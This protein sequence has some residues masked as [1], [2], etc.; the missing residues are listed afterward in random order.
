M[1][2]RRRKKNPAVSIPTTEPSLAA[3]GPATNSKA[4]S[5]ACSGCRVH[6]IACK[7][8][9]GETICIKCTE[10]GHS[11]ECVIQP[12]RTRQR[13]NSAL[14]HELPSK[15]TA[16]K[17]RAPTP[18]FTTTT[19]NRQQTPQLSDIAPHAKRQC[20]SSLHKPTDV[21]ALGLLASGFNSVPELDEFDDLHGLER[22]SDQTAEFGDPV[23]FMSAVMSGGPID[24]DSELEVDGDETQCHEYFDLE[25]ITTGSEDDKSSLGDSDTDDG[26][27]TLIEQRCPYLQ[28]VAKYAHTKRLP[29]AKPASKTKASMEPS[30]DPATCV[31]KIRGAVLQS[32][33]AKT[34]QIQFQIS[35]DVTLD[36]LR[37]LVAEKLRRFP[38]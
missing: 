27:S 32:Q 6:K 1:S 9:P 20:S 10:N 25:Q 28:P 2:Q 15:P 38:A 16:H 12:T 34:S 17:Q 31:F 22:S 26:L 19:S 29:P 18:Q 21:G 13:S 33:G 8:A 23:E 3:P 30:Y 14:P 7:F 37:T 24:F 11:E 36:E 4:K 5:G 35:S